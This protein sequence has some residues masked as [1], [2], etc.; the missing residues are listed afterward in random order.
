MIPVMKSFS[1]ILAVIFF[2]LPAIYI[3]FWFVIQC[4]LGG[5]PIVPFVVFMGLAMVAAVYLQAC[6]RSPIILA[7]RSK[8]KK[9]LHIENEGLILGLF[10]FGFMALIMGNM[11][12]SFSYSAC[13]NPQ[14]LTLN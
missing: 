13:L 7:F 1:Y 2:N 9:S 11:V 5:F 6:R 12:A 14:V 8:L 4:E 10:L 3:S